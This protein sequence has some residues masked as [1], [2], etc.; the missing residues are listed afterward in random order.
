M[1]WLAG[2]TALAV[3]AG[4][5]VATGPARAESLRLTGFVYA[6]GRSSSYYEAEV[7]YSHNSA[8]ARNHIR[9]NSIGNYTVEFAGLGSPGGIAHAAAYGWEGSYCVVAGWYDAGNYEAV[10]VLCYSATG[11]MADSPFLASFSDGPLVPGLG[12]PRVSYL[13]ADWAANSARYTPN[14]AYRY[15][16]TGGTPWVQRLDPGRYEVYVPAAAGLAGTPQ[17]FQVTP[18]GLWARHCKLARYQSADG[19]VQVACTDRDGRPADSMFTLTFVQ[20]GNMVGRGDRIF[21]YAHI[22][23]GWPVATVPGVLYEDSVFALPTTVE[24]F[25]RGLFRVNFGGMAAA[26]GHAAVVA[27]MPYPT[28]CNVHSWGG[29]G[30]DMAVWVRCFDS[31]SHAPVDGEFLVAVTW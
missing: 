26:Q 8:G 25:S 18:V 30:K 12:W 19:V 20:V 14:P 7:W 13:Y 2:F 28:Y 27:T 23:M 15:D 31:V 24:R 21:G 3:V 9:R 6:D 22:V 29:L 1:R 17:S 16:S 4:L 10:T 11:A 5:G